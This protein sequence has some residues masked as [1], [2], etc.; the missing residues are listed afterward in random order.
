MRHP[1]QAPLGTI[2]EPCQ[3]G[4]EALRILFEGKASHQMRLLRRIAEVV[5]ITTL[6]GVCPPD[7][8]IDCAKPFGLA[9]ERRGFGKTGEEPA[10]V[11]QRRL[12]AV[13]GRASPHGD[14]A[15][16]LHAQLLP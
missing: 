16:A 14:R 6:P 2:A 12:K 13:E 1:R 10:A 8:A 4:L 15:V 11:A 5:V 3:R 7:D 9:S